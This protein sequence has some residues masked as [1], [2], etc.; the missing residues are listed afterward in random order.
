MELLLTRNAPTD[1]F[2]MGA[3]SEGGKKLCDTLEDPPREEKV[4]G[5]T[6]IPVGRYNVDVTF[7]NRFKKRMPLIK[8]VPGFEGI[9]IHGGRDEKDTE[10]CILVGYK[11]SE[12]LLMGGPGVSQMI[13]DMIEKILYLED[14]WITIK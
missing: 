2:V 3:L 10:G 8:E 11:A 6:G 1:Y 5:K 14:V 9:R 7:S 12:G 4:P 13:C